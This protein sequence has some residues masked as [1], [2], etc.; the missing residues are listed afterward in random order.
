VKWE[1]FSEHCNSKAIKK[2][3]P[4]IMFYEERIVSQFKNYNFRELLSAANLENVRQTK[5]FV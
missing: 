4:T 2:T 3:L 1:Y 5:K